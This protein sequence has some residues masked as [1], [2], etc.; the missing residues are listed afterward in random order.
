MAIF[1]PKQV[2]VLLNGREIS[3]W[4]DGSDVINLTAN[5]PAGAYTMG[6]GGTGVFVANPDGSG[7]LTLKIKQHSPDNEFLSKLFNK[8]KANIK[9]ASALTLS[10]RDLINDDTATGVKGYFTDSPAYARGNGHNATT[11]V[12]EFERVT[13]KLEKGV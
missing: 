1:D 2:T 12:I 11:W 7:K 5:Q 9:I 6:V 13:I 4:A 3:D 8:Q 10:I